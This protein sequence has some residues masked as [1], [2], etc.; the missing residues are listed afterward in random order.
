MIGFNCDR[1]ESLSFEKIQEYK[2][3]KSHRI[4]KKN[5]EDKIESTNHHI[6]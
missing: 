3:K 4:F 1:E 5:T 6:Q 2:K